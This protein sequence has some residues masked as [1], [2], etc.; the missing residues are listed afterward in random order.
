MAPAPRK[1]TPKLPLRDWVSD[2]LRQR[3]ITGNLVPGQ[4]LIE[5]D[6]ALRLHVSRLPVREALRV[7]EAEGLVAAEPGKRSIVV[8]RFSLRDVEE[9]FDVRE[10]LE[11]LAA[12]QAAT[13]ATNAELARLSHIAVS[14]ASSANSG[15]AKKAMSSQESFHDTLIDLAHNDLLREILQPVQARLHWLFRQGGD[16]KQ[17]CEEH[18][19]LAD[20]IATRD[21]DLAAKEALAHVQLNRSAAVRIHFGDL[22]AQKRK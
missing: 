20:A 11:V 10:A 8:R 15:D 18:L 9:L 12:R 2:Q 17:L 7:L 1:T 21:P 19:K 3:I 16:P 14:G 4:R 5:R 13:Q 22:P 6:L